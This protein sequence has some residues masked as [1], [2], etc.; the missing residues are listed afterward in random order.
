MSFSL[1]FAWGQ[2]SLLVCHLFHYSAKGADREIKIG[3]QFSDGGTR[4]LDISQ[5]EQQLVDVVDVEIGDFLRVRF[6]EEFKCFPHTS[7]NRLL[8]KDLIDGGEVDQKYRRGCRLGQQ[9]E[10]LLK[11]LDPPWLA[12]K[13]H[14]GNAG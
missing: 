10:E 2:G 1:P 11:W 13:T 7:Q 6:W 8:V 9:Q 12:Q 5:C 4:A 3:D 14:G